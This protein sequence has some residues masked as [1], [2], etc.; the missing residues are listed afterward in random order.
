MESHRSLGSFS[1]EVIVHTCPL[2]GVLREHRAGGQGVAPGRLPMVSARCMGG[3][4]EESFPLSPALPPF[5]GHPHHGH[6]Q[7]TYVQACSAVSI[8]LQLHGL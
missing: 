6:S 1:S 7:G 2:M 3:P 4:G 5:S 8:S